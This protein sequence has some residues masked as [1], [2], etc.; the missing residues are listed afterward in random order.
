MKAKH[1]NL[2][3]EKNAAPQEVVDVAR[4]SITLPKEI[5]DKDKVM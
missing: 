5:I 3:E 2:E 1:K 4:S